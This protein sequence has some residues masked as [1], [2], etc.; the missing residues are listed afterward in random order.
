LFCALTAP[1]WA[2]NH[3][4]PA[5]HGD[6]SRTL[7][8]DG[9][10]VVV[11]IVDSGVDDTH[12]ALTGLDSLGNPRMVAE[13]DFVPGEGPSA[14]DV[15]GHGTW[16]SSAALSSDATYT[17]MATDA[18]FV[19]ARV[20]NNTG[21]FDNDVQVKNGIGF[22]IEQGADVLNL[23]LNFFAATSSGT[24]QLDLMLDWAAF[25]RGINCALCVGN[26]GS[27][28][29]QLVRGPGSAYN[30]LTVGR[31]TA[32]YSR[33]HTDSANAFTADGRMK[34]DVVA[35]GTGLTLANDDWEDAA[36]DW[37]SG[38]NGCSFATPHVAGLMAQQL[39]AG[40]THGLS[41]DPLVVK[42]TIMNSAS[43]SVLDKQGNAWEPGQAGSTTNIGGVYTV[44]QPLDLHA[45]A[46]QVDGLSLATQYLAGEM[47]PGLVDPIG[48][49]LNSLGAGQFVDYVIDPNLVLGSSLTATLTW[50][51]HVTRTDGGTIGAIDAGDFFTGQALRDLD[52]QIL[53]NGTL[54][55]ESTSN[56]DNVEH[57]RI[58]VD[59]HTP[60]TL[61]VRGLGSFT[62]SEQFALAWYGTAVPEPA[63]LTTLAIAAIGFCLRRRRGG[64]NSV[65]IT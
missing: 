27:S 40:A 16:V 3:S 58:N 38:L 17:G 20:L 33:V 4:V 26:I 46:G 61:R 34:P 12:P 50:Y 11:G 54:I 6:V 47:G 7:L 31:T 63:S 13:A 51:R 21:G 37:D 57:L 8:G 65:R 52:L 30:G 23:S 10:G 53:R 62:G 42:A 49:D 14:D 56:V 59:Q 60:F 39:E 32:D 5:I 19:N 9:T 1:A 18:R 2:I 64:V 29:T 44:T 35:P 55:A 15:F 41:T 36:A 24:S 48:W 22:A 25:N 45:G 43:K 28:G